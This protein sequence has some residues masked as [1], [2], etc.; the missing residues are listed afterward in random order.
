ML[1]NN[2]KLGMQTTYKSKQEE[3]G[4]DDVA[5]IKKW[6]KIHFVAV[7]ARYRNFVREAEKRVEIHFLLLAII[8][9][10]ITPVRWE[11]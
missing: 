2:L 10:E 8:M 11:R 9:E 3:L 1:M 5:S 6:K 4:K 7:I